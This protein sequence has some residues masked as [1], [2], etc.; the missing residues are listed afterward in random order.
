M[1]I[2]D[3]IA[4]N[5]EHWLNIDGYDNYQVSNFGRIRNCTTDRILK[6]SVDARGHGYKN[7]SLYKDGKKKSHCIHQLVANEFIE[8]PDG[9]N[10]VDHIDKNRLNNIVENLRWVSSSENNRNRSMMTNNTSGFKGVCYYKHKNKYRAL[11]YHEGKNHHLGYFDTAE[12]AAKAYD[13]KAKEIDSVH[14]TVN[15]N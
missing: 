6:G 11:I 2:A 13:K 15:F 3:N 10:Y 9:K 12:Q 1:N 4:N 8:K 7:V 5:I 14:F